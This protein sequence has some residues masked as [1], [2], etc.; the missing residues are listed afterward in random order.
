MKIKKNG[1][2]VPVS[3]T[4]TAIWSSRVKD[5]RGDNS[6]IIKGNLLNCWDT[7]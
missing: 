7:V 5:V 4:N 6:N 1:F 2:C 3:G